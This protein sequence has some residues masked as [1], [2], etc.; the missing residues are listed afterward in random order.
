MWTRA[1]L[2]E[3][4]WEDMGDGAHAGTAKR[5]RERRLRAMLR[6]ERM[7]VAMVLSEKKHHTSRGQRK[8]RT[9][10]EEYVMNYTVKLRKTPHP[11]AAATKDYPTALDV[12]GDAVGERPDALF[13]PYS[14]IG[15]ELL[16]ALDVPVLQMVEQPVV[17]VFARHATQVPVQVIEVPKILIDVIPA[18]SLVPEPQVVEQLVDVPTLLTP[19]R[20]ALQIAEQIV[21]IPVPQ[22]RFLVEV[23]KVLSL[24]RV[25]SASRSLTFQFHVVVV[26]G[27][28]KVFSQ[29]RVQQRSPSSRSLTFLLVVALDRVLPHLLLLQIRIFLGFFALFLLKKSA[30]CQAGQ[31]GPAPARQLIHAGGSARL[32]VGVTHSCSAGRVGGGPGGSGEGA[33]EQEE[34]EEEEE[35]AVAEV[36]RATSFSFRN[37]HSEIWTLFYVLDSDPEVVPD[38]LHSSTLPWY[39][40]AT[41]SVF[42]LPGIYRKIGFSAR[43]LQSLFPTS[44]LYLAVTLLCLVLPLEKRTVDFPGDDSRNGFRTQHSSV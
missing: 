27:E 13:A 9:T 10:G 25:R 7:T 15:Y 44:P 17:G 11:K 33:R 24:D 8:D 14:G 6:H 26:S 42:A 38:F 3:P 31:C 5:R 37:S 16:L 40:A 21:D 30:E 34:E 4:W 39:L 23:I 18:H 12:G 36:L 32:V 22:F 41:G 28:F 20:I 35:E 2:S 1:P 43:R 19:T 29:N